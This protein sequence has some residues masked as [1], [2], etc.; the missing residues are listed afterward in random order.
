MVYPSLLEKSR[1]WMMNRLIDCDERE[2]GRIASQ[3][4]DCTNC[5]HW[6]TS[7]RTS[8]GFCYM[9]AE[10]VVKFDRTALTCR[11]YRYELPQEK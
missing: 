11:M 3:A 9:K 8:K 10:E 2:S 5:I 4:K 6:F 7:P 1:H